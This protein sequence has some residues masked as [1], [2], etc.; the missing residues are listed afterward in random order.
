M[1]DVITQT[2]DSNGNQETTIKPQ[3]FDNQWQHLVPVSLVDPIED[4]AQLV[5]ALDSDRTPPVNDLQI[6][7]IKG[8]DF[9]KP[10]VQLSFYATETVPNIVIQELNSSNND[11]LIK[12]LGYTPDG[13]S[14]TV[15]SKI[16]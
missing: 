11:L 1:T 15:E 7:V 2:V 4:L 13:I 3:G 8:P 9:P 10:F 6:T 5:R 16:F 12:D 14:V